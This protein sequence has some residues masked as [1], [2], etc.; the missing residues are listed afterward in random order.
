ML[1]ERIRKDFCPFISFGDFSTHLPFGEHLLTTVSPFGVSF[2][3]QCYPLMLLAHMY[4]F[5]ISRHLTKRIGGH[6][7]VIDPD[8]G[9]DR[10]KAGNYHELALK[11][12]QDF[13]SSFY[14][15]LVLIDFVIELLGL[16][17]KPSFTKRLLTNQTNQNESTD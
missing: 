13:F 17:I 5:W 3:L 4:F 6:P 14:F 15:L 8:V 1:K 10:R 11:W 9:N 12:K 2:P 16:I 7:L